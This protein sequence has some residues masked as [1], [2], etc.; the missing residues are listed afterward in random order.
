MLSYKNNKERSME[1]PKEHL[2]KRWILKV[3]E[4]GSRIHIVTDEHEPWHLVEALLDVEGDTTGL[5][6]LEHIC[7][8][9]NNSLDKSPKT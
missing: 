4:E 2:K 7:E 1:H 8:L 5:H 6:T 3:N 9:H